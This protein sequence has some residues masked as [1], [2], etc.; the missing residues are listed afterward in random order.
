MLL[1][2]LERFP[3]YTLTTLLDESDELIH[4]VNIRERGASRGQQD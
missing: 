4:L 3:G 1:G 2:L